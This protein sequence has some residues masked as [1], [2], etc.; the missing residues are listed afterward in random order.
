[1][2]NEMEYTQSTAAQKFES[3]T[4]ESDGTKEGTV[5]K[6]NGK[7]IKNVASSYFCFW[8]DTY[9]NNVCFEFSTKDLKAEPGTL[10]QTV[11]FRLCP[12]LAS[13]SANATD[14]KIEQGSANT[15]WHSRTEFNREFYKKI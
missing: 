1:M 7:A 4:I 3:I 15:K 5:I 14:A 2:E 9:G 6:V 12:P 10:Q 11:Y 13:A 8:N